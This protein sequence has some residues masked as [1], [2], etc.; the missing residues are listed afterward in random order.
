MNYSKRAKSFGVKLVW[1]S[2]VIKNGGYNV[3]GSFKS[4]PLGVI[5]I[6]DNLTADMTKKVFE[7]EL[8]QLV[9][10]QPIHKTSAPALHLNS[11]ST[12][13]RYMV[14]EKAKEWVLGFNGDYH[15]VKIDNF[16]GWAGLS[17]DYYRLAK[18]E[19]E[20]VLAP[21]AASFI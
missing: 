5:F 14:H 6:Q 11:E 12:A 8:G 13:N 4:Y 2:K 18:E 1:S 15:M 19:L 16:L 3:A 17:N 20:E 9:K 21:Y 7:H 10:G